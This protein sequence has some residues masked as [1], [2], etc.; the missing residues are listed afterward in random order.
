MSDED[1]PNIGSD[2]DGRL[3]DVDWESKG[4]ELGLESNSEFIPSQASRSRTPSYATGGGQL[5]AQC[6]PYSATIYH[7]AG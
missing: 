1:I 7:L 4:K 6:P 5:T 3:Q 2:R